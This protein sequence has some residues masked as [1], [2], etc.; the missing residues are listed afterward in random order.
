MAITA[1]MVRELR[2]RSGAGMMECKKALE[3]AGGDREGAFDYLRKAGLKTAARKSSREMAEGA[4]AVRI[5]DD[6]RAGAMLALTTETDFVVRSENV[7]R[8]LGELVEHALSQRPGDAGEMLAQPW[9]SGGTVEEAI[10]EIVARTGENMQLARVHVLENPA[11]RVGSYLHHDGKAGALL[12]VSTAAEEEKADVFIKSLGMHAVALKPTVL[13]REEIAPAVL[14]RETGI[15]RA[16]VEKKPENIQEK[17]I[18]GK[19]EKF[20]AGTVLVEQPWVMDDKKTVQK[21]LQEELGPDSRIEAFHLL[22][23]G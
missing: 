22:Q 19:L 3:A 23:I 7:V 1:Q 11:G 5:A 15:Y 17:I 12:S 21:A 20:Y 16:E 6:R 8:L 10:K 13:N 2:E 4:V 9:S 14:E 18:Q